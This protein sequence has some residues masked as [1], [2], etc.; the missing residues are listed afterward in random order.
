MTLLVQAADLNGCLKTIHD[1]PDARDF[2]GPQI[3]QLRL[4]SIPSEQN[5]ELEVEF[6]A[7]QLPSHVV[8]MGGEYD[9]G[10]PWILLLEFAS[11]GPERPAGDSVAR[12]TDTLGQF[13]ERVV[14]STP[15]VVE[16][17]NWVIDPAELRAY[18]EWAADD[19]D[20][21]VALTFCEQLRGLVAEVCGY[22]IAELVARS[23]EACAFPDDDHECQGELLADVF[24]GWIDGLI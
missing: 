20:V 3:A 2:V 1:E 7:A 6:L 16:L 13:F 9:D 10:T 15:D 8:S 23:G 4:L 5:L 22:P 14:S 17:R 11:V 18:Y 19:A 21:V 24:Q 12:A